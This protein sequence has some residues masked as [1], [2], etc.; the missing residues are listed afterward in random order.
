MT[1]TEKIYL[2]AEII[3][4]LVLERD[5][6]LTNYKELRICY[7]NH[8]TDRQLLNVTKPDFHTVYSH[9]TDT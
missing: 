4:M 1:N 8:V 3:V 2:P 9:T 6:K 5:L 7:C